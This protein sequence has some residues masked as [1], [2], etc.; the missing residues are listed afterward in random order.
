MASCKYIVTIYFFANVWKRIL[1]MLSVA[2]AFSKL[3][4]TFVVT[5]LGAYGPWS[6]GIARSLSGGVKTVL[7]LILALAGGCT[8]C[9]GGAL[10]HFPCKLHLKNFFS[11]LWGCRCTYCTPWLRLCLEGLRVYKLWCY[12]D[13]VSDFWQSSSCSNRCG[14]IWARMSSSTQHSMTFGSSFTLAM[15]RCHDLSTLEKRL[16]SA[17]SCLAISPPTKTASR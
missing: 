12:T 10:T 11:P 8:S 17:G 14:S 15:I 9:P 4:L 3:V 7:K 1:H 5:A 2:I 16:A 13:P 6:I